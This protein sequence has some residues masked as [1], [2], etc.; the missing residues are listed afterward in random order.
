M[1]GEILSGAA[2]IGGMIGGAIARRRAMRKAM[3]EERKAS[4]AEQANIDAMSAKQKNIENANGMQLASTQRMLAA[5][6]KRMADRRKQNRALAGMGMMNAGTAE[7][8]SGGNETAELASNALLAQQQRADGAVQS[9]QQLMAQ[10]NAVI[11]GEADKIA[12]MHM[13][14]ADAVS[15]AASQI[16]TQV[17]GML[18][19]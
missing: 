5:V 19:K 17:G 14:Q 11:Q 6:D 1:V 4:E 9:Q 8:L 3:N 2:Q 7:Q 16:G 10:K 18:K 12:Q 15:Q 13:K